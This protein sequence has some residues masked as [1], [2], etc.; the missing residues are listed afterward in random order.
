M[1]GKQAER[2]ARLCDGDILQHA[3]GLVPASLSEMAERCDMAA[4]AR[5]RCEVPRG[6]VAGKR[7]GGCLMIGGKAVEIALQHMRHDEA[8]ILGDRR[9]H[10]ADRIADEALQFVQCLGVVSCTDGIRAR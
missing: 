8:G 5:C 1:S 3:A 6:L 9:V 4:L 10:R 7:H 2:V